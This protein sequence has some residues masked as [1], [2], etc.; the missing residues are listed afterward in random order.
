MQPGLA[1][2]PKGTGHAQEEKDGEYRY[3]DYHHFR[4]PWS[5]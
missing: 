2:P 3:D 5:F 1:R 4:H